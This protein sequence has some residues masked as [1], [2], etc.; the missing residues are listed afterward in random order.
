[1]EF[2]FNMNAMLDFSDFIYQP[3]LYIL[4]TKKITH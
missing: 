2:N 4:S 3:K 1:M